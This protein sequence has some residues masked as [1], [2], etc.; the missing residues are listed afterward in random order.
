MEMH[1]NF[2]NHGFLGGGHALGKK[3]ADRSGFEGSWTTTPN[4]ITNNYFVSLLEE[5]WE[6]YVVESSGKKQFKAVGKELYMLKT[7][8]MLLYD[9][10]FTSIVEEFASDANSFL[11]TFAQAWTHIMNIDRY[12]I[13]FLRL[14]DFE[15]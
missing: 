6:E 14:Y 8:M 4:R 3:H 11:E 10:E 5:T 13:Y 1:R 15:L 7:D 12:A 2:L 9:P